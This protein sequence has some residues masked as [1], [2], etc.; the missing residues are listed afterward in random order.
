METAEYLLGTGHVLT[1]D[2]ESG[3]GIL[4]SKFRDENRRVAGVS[5]RAIAYDIAPGH[6]CLNATKERAD[7]FELEPLSC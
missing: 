3:I 6:I 7:A 2:V 4:I 5:C 1:Y